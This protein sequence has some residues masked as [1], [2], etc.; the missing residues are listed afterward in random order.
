MKDTA[1]DDNIQ[2]P[3]NRQPA[4]RI[5]TMPADANPAGHIF[6][7]WIMSQMDV[8][9]AIV[10]VEYAASRVATVAVTQMEFHKPVFVGDLIS[11]F[12][13]I[14]KTGRSSI[15]VGVEVFAQRGRGGDVKYVKVTAAVIVYVAVDDDGTP[16]QLPERQSEFSEYL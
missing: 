15:T 1:N 12:A 16:Q 5:L 10:A 13:R 2:F 11:C 7:G 4:L 8:A 14:E 9:G 3:R 6:G